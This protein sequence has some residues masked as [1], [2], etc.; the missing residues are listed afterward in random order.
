MKSC[1]S[2][3]QV[4]RIE[5]EAF[6]RGVKQALKDVLSCLALELLDKRGMSRKETKDIID[7]ISE[8][9]DSIINGYL[10]LKDITKVLKDEYD[11][12]IIYD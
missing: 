2:V 10:E 9:F 6:K 5:N 11:I 12:E 8:Q 7:K 4:K 3:Q 1:Y